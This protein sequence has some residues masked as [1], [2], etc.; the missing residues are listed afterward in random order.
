[1]SGI[2]TWEVLSWFVVAVTIAVGLC[3]GA[4]WKIWSLIDQVREELQEKLSDTDKELGDTKKALADHQLH[5]AQTYVTQKGMQE[6]TS[7]IMRGIESLGTRIDGQM[8]A[9]TDRLDR[10]YQNSP[11]SRRSRGSQE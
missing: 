1:M 6:Q 10:L 9:V 2:V 5:V 11:A 4:F 3:F 8:A 7:Q